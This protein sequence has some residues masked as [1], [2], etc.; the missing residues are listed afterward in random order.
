MTSI[1]YLTVIGWLFDALLM[2]LQTPI[3]EEIADEYTDGDAL[4][5]E[6]ISN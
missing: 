4:G 3:V 5:L 2:F 1:T 6:Y